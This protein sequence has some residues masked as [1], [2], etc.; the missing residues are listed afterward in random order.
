MKKWALFTASL[1]LLFSWASAQDDTYYDNSYARM[2]YVSGDTY[3]QR[4]QDLGQEAGTVNLAVISGDALGT[5][6]GR[7]E[8]HFGQQNYLRMDNQS[9]LEVIQLPSKNLDFVKLHLKSGEVFLRISYLGEDQGFEIHTPDASFYVLEE[10]LYR[11]RSGEAGETEL[12]VIEGSIEA[13]GENASEV[14]HAMEHLVADEGRF[15]LGPTRGAASLSAD[16]FSDWNHGRDALLAKPASTYL[17]EEL[18]AYE[19]ELAAGG[20][21]TYESP[22]GYVWVPHVYHDT[23]RP[24][25]YGR[26]VWYPIIG[27]TWV[28]SHSWGWCV[29][30]Y[31][32]W[33]WR[34]GMGWY[35]IPRCGWGPAWVHWHHGAHHYGWSALS[36]HG[37]PGTIV[38]NHYY[39]DRYYGSYAADSRTM[40]TVRKNQLSDPNISRVALS[41]SQAKGMG[42]VQLSSRQPAS[43]LAAGTSRGIGSARVSS[44]SSLKTYD[45]SGASRVSGGSA[46]RS[47]NAVSSGRTAGSTARTTD[48]KSYPSRSSRSGSSATLKST[49]TGSRTA[50]REAQARASAS[51]TGR[52]D[53]TASQTYPSRS[54]ASAGR[55]AASSRATST[56]RSAPQTYPSR[57]GGSVGRTSS[58]QSRTASRTAGSYPSRTARGVSQQSP[59]RGVSGTTSRSYPSRTPRSTGRSS[60]SSASPRSPSRSQSARS[61][62]R[63]A[64]AYSTPSRTQTQRPTTSRSASSRS[65]SLSYRTSPSRSS[66]SN[67]SSPS[68]SSSRV[69]SSQRS[70]SPSYRTSP[71][72]SSSSNRSSSVRSSPSRSS[73]S[74]ARSS[75]R[76]ASSASRSSGRS[77]GS[78]AR[79]AGRNTGSSR[80][81]SSSRSGT[82]VRKR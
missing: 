71:S 33:Q 79:S 36:Y 67:R 46:S 50:G 31:G 16:A 40:V 26:W 64:P 55:T 53:R 24:Y 6:E 78:A 65:S 80:A 30:H 60:P 82:R 37:Y 38:N 22:Y 75:G 61:T 17:P 74:S 62:S 63:S 19:G 9:Q 29:S 43:D 21:W 5:R 69:G 12:S 66:S 70:S 7:L 44:R 52:S 45:R 14:V 25:S 41:R 42:K 73:S 4:A 68:R 49:P 77:A 1:I 2:S 39:G 28:S 81:S 34:F 15:I 32:R 20:R 54:S 23:W 35:W 13:A 51:L 27:Y 56:A 58:S 3:V 48:T 10:G 59:S 72:R 8:I 47:G 18:S 76:S 57:A 11:I